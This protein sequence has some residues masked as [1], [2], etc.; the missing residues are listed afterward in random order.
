MEEVL[1]GCVLPWLNL[2]RSLVLRPALSARAGGTGQGGARQTWMGMMCC[3]KWWPL[4]NNCLS[5]VGMCGMPRKVHKQA[6]TQV[7]GGPTVP[8]AGQAQSRQGRWSPAAPCGLAVMAKVCV[9]NDWRSSHLQSRRSGGVEQRA[10]QT[11][12]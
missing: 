5:P 10:V 2:V 4:G 6:V 11:W 9:A 12:W 3:F 8:R 7:S 1:G